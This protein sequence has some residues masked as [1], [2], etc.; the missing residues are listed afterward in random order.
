METQIPNAA[1]GKIPTFLGAI[2]VV[3][4]FMAALVSLALSFS[5]VPSQV[6]PWTGLLLV[7]EWTFTIFFL[8]FGS[9]LYIIR[10][11]GK[12][13]ARQSSFLSHPESS[14]YD[15]GKG[16]FYFRK[17][18]IV[19]PVCILHLQIIIV[20]V[21]FLLGHVRQ[22]SSCDVSTWYYGLGMASLALAI[23]LLPCF[24][25]ITALFM[26]YYI[27]SPCSFRYIFTILTK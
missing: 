22:L 14:D 18:I 9:Y 4:C 16:I 26:R 24:L 21:W 20:N 27:A 13:V 5:I 2:S 17:I 3:V 6:M 10:Q 12:H 25:G 19:D 23:P 1:L 7:Y 15:S 8:L 11:W